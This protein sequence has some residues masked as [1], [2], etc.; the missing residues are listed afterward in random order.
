MEHKKSEKSCRR[1]FSIRSGGFTLVEL[2]VAVC[3][4]VIAAIPLLKTF[5]SSFYTNAKARESLTAM[6]VAE[7][8]MESLKGHKFEDIEGQFKR[9]ADGDTVSFNL[10]PEKMVRG[11]TDMKVNI[12]EHPEGDVFEVRLENIHAKSAADHKY[13]ATVSLNA[14][15]F[16]VESSTV[17]YNSYNSFPLVSSMSMNNVYDAFFYT[18]SYSY[19]LD[20]ALNTIE[21]IYPE[22]FTDPD[23]AI[24]K[25]DL[26]R[27]IVATVEKNGDR[28]QAYVT[29]KFYLPSED[30]YPIFQKKYPVYDNV[31]TL[32]NG[33]TLK[34]FYLF[35][36]PGYELKEGSYS[37][38]KENP[39]SKF[40][41]DKAADYVYTGGGPNDTVILE[42]LSDV[43][44]TFYVAKQIRVNSGA[45]YD[46]GNLY[47][48]ELEYNPFVVIK[49]SAHGG[50]MHTQVC[51][52]LNLNL[53]TEEPLPEGK[54]TVANNFRVLFGNSVPAL[55]DFDPFRGL[56]GEARDRIFGAYVEIF[57]EKSGF[58]REKR[59]AELG[60]TKI[61]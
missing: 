8:I 55:D 17:S 15:M 29:E 58:N 21:S 48:E 46:V 9:Y 22:Y 6:M 37:T 3:I 4:L 14:A 51:S 20:E 27:L 60:S 52:N 18:G 49:E 32:V 16:R 7:D 50:Q 12:V 10:F 34:N 33:G 36:Y 13:D 41:K 61:D 5:I 24:D 54:V 57:K 19:E 35:Y 26:S 45:G 40:N 2:L 23:T 38:S 1:A 31:D 25:E 28:I 11:D 42:N 44:F 47:A 43:D 53:V 30:K 56:V 39:D 59:L